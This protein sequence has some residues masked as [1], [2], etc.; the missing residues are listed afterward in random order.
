LRQSAGLDGQI[1][2]LFAAHNFALK[3]LGTVL[4]ALKRVDR[5]DFHLVVA[6]RGNRD[7]Y[8]RLAGRLGIADQVTFTGFVPDIRD[9]YAVADA[10]VQPTFYDPCSLAILEAA[11]SGVAVVTSRFNGASELFRD[12]QS[13]SVVA[14]PEDEV[15]VARHIGALVDPDYRARLAAGGIAV[16]RQATAEGSFSRLFDLCSETAGQRSS[17]CRA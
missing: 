13:A 1:V 12:G 7:R 4:R 14:D 3:G 11:A 10:F 2:L 6:G 15:E 9:S 8:S 16:A 17:R 5:P